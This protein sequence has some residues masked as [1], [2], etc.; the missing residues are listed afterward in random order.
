[1]AR[2]ECYHMTRS[3]A[4]VRATAHDEDAERIAQHLQHGAKALEVS[5]CIRSRGAQLQLD[6]GNIAFGSRDVTLEIERL[7]NDDVGADLQA[8]L[9]GLLLIFLLDDGVVGQAQPLMQLSEQRTLIPAL[10]LEEAR[11]CD[12]G[13]RITDTY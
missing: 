5:Q 11:H 9:A 8:V 1:M 6:D 13:K 10:G 2:A 4:F 7:V 12:G 3:V